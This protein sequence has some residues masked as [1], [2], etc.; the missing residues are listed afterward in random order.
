MFWYGHVVHNNDITEDGVSS[1]PI[2]Y[3][4]Y[5]QQSNY[6]HLVISN[7]TIITDYGHLVVP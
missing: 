3:S 5:Y 4:L 6:T 1:P 7:C 2:I